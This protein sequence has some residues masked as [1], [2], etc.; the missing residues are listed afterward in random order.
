MLIDLFSFNLS[1][2][3]EFYSWYRFDIPDSVLGT[4]EEFAAI[5]PVIYFNEFM[6][7]FGNH[8]KIFV[9]PYLPRSEDQSPGKVDKYMKHLLRDLL[10]VIE[11]HIY[12]PFTRKGTITINGDRKIKKGSFVKLNKTNEL[13]YVE[14]VT[15]TAYLSKENCD[16]VTVLTV[17]RGMEFDHILGNKRT[18]YDFKQEGSRIT[19]KTSS[20]VDTGGTFA[21]LWSGDSGGFGFPVVEQRDIYKYSYFD[22]VDLDLI[23]QNIVTQQNINNGLPRTNK[24]SVN[25][26]SI[27]NKKVFD[28]FLKRR[29]W[30]E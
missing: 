23:E 8:S 7:H 26:K 11:T 25:Y 10:Y 2:E 15:N 19:K 16:R 6:Y 28:Y 24:T 12:L 30:K 29:Q 17:K 1:W 27:L 3:T 13:F 22:L 5:T 18:V 9:N 4:H 20:S 14:G 21:D